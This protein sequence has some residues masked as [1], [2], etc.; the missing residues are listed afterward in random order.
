MDKKCDTCGATFTP[1]RS[2][3]RFCSGRCR[4]LAYRQRR[5]EIAAPRRR[6]P[7]DD[8]FRDAG[9]DL[10]RIIGRWQRLLADDR[11]PRSRSKLAHRRY[12]LVRARDAIDAMLAKW[13]EPSQPTHL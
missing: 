6:R 1:A 4:T 2:D 3:A 9:L 12:A 5:G 10:D 11:F 7:L 8:G 13:P